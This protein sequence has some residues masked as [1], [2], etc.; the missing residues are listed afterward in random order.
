[1][2]VF[3]KELAPGVTPLVTAE[4]KQENDSTEIFTQN[5]TS[6]HMVNLPLPSHDLQIPK[7]N[8]RQQC[9][10]KESLKEQALLMA[11]IGSVIIGI[12]AGVALRG[13][14]CSTGKTVLRLFK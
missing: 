13:L 6:H 11:T 9:C 2:H 7:R 10:S 3:D 12:I 4:A 8:F 5:K 1:M 14:K